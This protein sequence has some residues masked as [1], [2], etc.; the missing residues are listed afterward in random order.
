M[1]RIDNWDTF[2]N[3]E[4]GERILPIPCGIYALKIVDA[5]DHSEEEGKEYLEL[6]FDIVR[7]ENAKYLKYFSKTSTKEKW[8]FQGTTR[9]YY[10]VKAMSLFKSRIMAIEK[11]NKGYSFAKSNFDEK[12]LIGKF[13]IGVFQEHEY[14]NKEGLV[15]KAVRLESMRSTEAWQDEKCRADMEKQAHK[16]ITL[17]D[18]KKERPAEPAPEQKKTASAIE[19]DDD[20]PF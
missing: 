7:S 19:D 5:I 10:S 18:Q 14:V 13:F 20:L 6:H 15:A 12:T 11:S 3:S 16:L 1:K 17:E 2:G 9:L 4:E 8:N